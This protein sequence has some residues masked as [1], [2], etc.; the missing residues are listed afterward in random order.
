MFVI[1]VSADAAVHRACS[2]IANGL[3]FLIR[4]LCR[5][6]DDR[7]FGLCEAYSIAREEIE[8]IGAAAS[9]CPEAGAGRRHAK[10]TIRG[11]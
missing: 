11:P 9:P 2:R 6:A 3:G 4:P 7:D 1:D 8:K 10:E 5:S